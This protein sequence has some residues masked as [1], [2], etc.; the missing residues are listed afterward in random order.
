MS[1][2]ETYLK[3]VKVND[4]TKTKIEAM[5]EEYGGKTSVSGAVCIEC[6]TPWAEW[7]ERFATEMEKCF[8]ERPGFVSFRH[9]KLLKEYEDFIDKEV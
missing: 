7:C 9:E 5:A 8:E 3:E 4:K 1:K 6:A 2:L